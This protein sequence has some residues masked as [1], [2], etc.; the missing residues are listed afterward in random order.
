MNDIEFND[1]CPNEK[2]LDRPSFNNPQ[3]PQNFS[4]RWRHSTSSKSPALKTIMLFKNALKYHCFS[5]ASQKMTKSAKS[6]TT[7]NLKEFTHPLSL[8]DPARDYQP[9]LKAI[10]PA[11]IVLI[12][13]SSH[14]T[15]E[16]YKERAEISRLL[17]KEK[18]FK[19]VILE[20]DFP[21]AHVVNRYVKGGGVSEQELSSHPLSTFKRFPR[22][23]WKNEVMLGFVEWLKTYNDVTYSNS[24]KSKISLYGMDVY[25]LHTSINAVIEYL[26][27][28]DPQAAVKARSRYGCFHRFGDDTTSYAFATRYGV[29]KSCEEEAIKVL[30]DILVAKSKYQESKA[31]QGGILD[32]EETFAATMNAMVV[33]DAENY[34]R[35]MLREDVDTWN[36]RDTHMTDVIAQIISHLQQIHGQNEVKVIVWAHNSH[37][38]DAT[39]TDMGAKRGEVNVGQLCREKFGNESVYNIGFLT[40]TGTVTAAHQWDSQ[41]HLLKVN[42]ARP[43]SIEQFLSDNGGTTGTNQQFI[44]PIKKIIQSDEPASSEKRFAKVDISHSLTTFL[45]ATPR[46]ERFIGVIYKPLTERW[47]HYSSVTLANQFD[48]VVHFERTRGIY[49]LEPSS[50]FP[51]ASM[52]R[53]AKLFMEKEE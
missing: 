37:L 43:D 21:D 24:A 36:L 13:D 11:K 38:G 32:F 14:G 45:N 33:K 20:A 15:Y 18:G 53:G 47:S 44:L 42:N 41:E 26:E 46:L 10:G 22:W 16:H 35:H 5:I 2:E 39:A 34:Y 17:I 48:A 51:D 29:A 28:V 40:N 7:I 8:Q 27:K 31:T 50:D 19:A 12:G 4:F 30:R 49:P 52:E 25:S 9:L 23:M 6:T 3:N 1:Q